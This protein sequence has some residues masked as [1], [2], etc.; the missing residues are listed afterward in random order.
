MRIKKP[1]LV[2]FLGLGLLTSCTKDEGFTPEPDQDFRQEMRKFVMGLSKYAKQSR[3]EFLIIPQN[4]IELV[5][6]SGEP[7]GPAANDY[8]AA[9]DGNGQE[10]LFFGYDHDDRATDPA[11]TNRL[12]KYLNISKQAGNSILVSDYCSTAKNISNSYSWNR[13]NGFIS[14]AATE[15]E[16]NIIPKIAVHEENKLN[17]KNLSEAKNFLYLINPNGFTSKQAFIQA[18]T[19][20]NYDVLIM[21]LYFTDGQKFNNQEIAQL[22]KKANGGSRLLIS[23]MSIGEAEDYR[24]YW[25]ASWQKNRPS[26][27][28]A[29]NPDWK[30]NFKV[31][32]WDKE[33]QS[34]IYGNDKS[35]LRNILD[36]GFDGAYLDIIDAFHYFEDLQ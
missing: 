9:I 24:P 8:L 36:A 10:D 30:G 16:L 17:I 6:Q 32:Y 25:D 19:A 28:V 14:F 13:E 35:Y 1:L 27:I 23:Y 18:V 5:S 31:K 12:I 11:E 26:W 15:R 29:E 21:D 3:P 4:G 7:T 34:I 22:R 33:W 20:T 2:I